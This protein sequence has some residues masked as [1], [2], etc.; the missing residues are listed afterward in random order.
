MKLHRKITGTGAF[1]KGFLWALGWK[2]FRT[3]FCRKW[4]SSLLFWDPS[5]P[6][7]SGSIRRANSLQLLGWLEGSASS[8]LHLWVS[9][10]QS[11]I[12]NGK[13]KWKRLFHCWRGE[14]QNE[15]SGEGIFN[16]CFP[17]LSSPLGD[18]KAGDKILKP[19]NEHMEE[20]GKVLAATGV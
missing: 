5:F 19:H 18:L 3:G 16:N 12:E 17:C 9:K 11:K 1:W 10:Q 8:L 2:C 7:S 13:E 4:N 14:K 20:L 15:E 6:T